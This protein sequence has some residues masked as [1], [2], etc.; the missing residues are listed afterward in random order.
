LAFVFLQKIQSVDP[1]FAFDLL[2][3]RVEPSMG[4]AAMFAGHD[5]S[6][7]VASDMGIDIVGRYEIP[8]HFDIVAAVEYG[9][10]E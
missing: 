9:R 8:V 3:A 2:V 10:P 7:A 6:L 1:N 5:V 4:I